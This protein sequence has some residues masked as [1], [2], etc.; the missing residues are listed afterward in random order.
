MS[1]NSTPAFTDQE[2][3]TIFFFGHL[4]GLFQKKAMYQLTVNY[5]QPWFPQLPSY[6]TFGYRLNLLGQTFQA[7]G[8]AWLSG[9]KAEM[10]PE[11]DRVIDSFP[12]MLAKHGPAYS[13]KV[14]REIANKGYCPA[15]K[16]HFHGVR[17]HTIAQRRSGQLPLPDHIWLREAS[18]YDLSS[19]REQEIQ[20]PTSSV[21]GDKAYRAPDLAQMLTEQAT[22]LLTPYQKPKGSELSE[23]QKSYNRM[24][25][26]LSQP[27]ESFFN[28]LNEK[29][30]IQ[31]ACKV[32]STE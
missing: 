9:V 15:K 21:F 22:Q 11:L 10:Q 5:W 6:Q 7:L 20:L 24:V 27:I 18:V 13:A 19:V 12:V 31:H 23:T 4:N 3:I 2:L 28:W 25:N 29:T 17:R 26:R 1:N 16:T 14:A 8:G 32:R 30:Q